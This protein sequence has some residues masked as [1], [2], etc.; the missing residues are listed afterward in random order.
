MQGVRQDFS[1]QARGANFWGAATHHRFPAPQLVAVN[2]KALTSQ[3]LK[4]RRRVAALRNLAPCAGMS[5][6]LPHRDSRVGGAGW[7]TTLISN[8]KWQI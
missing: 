1:P 4:K 7:G 2:P 8:L 3:R 6:P 5:F